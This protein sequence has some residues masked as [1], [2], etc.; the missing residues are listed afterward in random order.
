MADRMSV[1]TIAGMLGRGC[2]SGGKAEAGLEIEAVVRPVGTRVVA[3][4]LGTEADEGPGAP[5]TTGGARVVTWCCVAVGGAGGQRVV[6]AG[7]A[8]A[9]GGK[10][11]RRWWT[12]IVGDAGKTEAD[13][14]AQEGCLP[15]MELG[16][17]IGI[18]EEVL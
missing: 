2:G 1:R 12:G 9:R 10:C 14:V 13:G 3:E 18:G 5:A 16:L 17:P 8:S 4:T 7:D 6:L 15:R 11:R